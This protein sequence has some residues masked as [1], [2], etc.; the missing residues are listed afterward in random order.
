MMATYDDT[1][2][3]VQFADWAFAQLPTWFGRGLNGN[4]GGRSRA[5][6]QLPTYILYLISGEVWV[7]ISRTF[8]YPWTLQPPVLVADRS[9]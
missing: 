3:R 7:A 1:I 6:L 9:E 2:Q 4:D 5:A 8:W